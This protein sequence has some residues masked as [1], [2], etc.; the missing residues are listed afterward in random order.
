MISA[1]EPLGPIAT[2]DIL[3]NADNRR[4]FDR[5]FDA[6]NFLCAAS[7]VTHPNI[8][9]GRRGAGKT[10]YL[11]Y[12]KF[13]GGFSFATSI[14]SAQVFREVSME[15]AK[16]VR[17][18]SSGSETIVET[19]AKLWRTLLLTT[20]LKTFW[21]QLHNRSVLRNT[22]EMKT[23]EA[24]L[25]RSGLKQKRSVRRILSQMIAMFESLGDMNLDFIEEFLNEY[26]WEDAG[27]GE[28][29][30][31]ATA[32]MHAHG[33]RGALLIDS[34]EQFP[35]HEKPMADA[36]GGLLHFIGQLELEYLPVEVTMCFQAELHREFAGL[37]RNPEKDLQRVLSMH[38]EPMELLQI[39]GHRFSV[40][41]QANPRVFPRSVDLLP[42]RPGR[43]DVV[44][45]WG[46]FLPQVIENRFGDEESS[47]AYILRHTQLLPRHVISILNQV[48]RLALAAREVTLPFDGEDVLRGVRLGEENICL[49][50]LSGF[51]MKYPQAREV[52][53]AI[54]PNIANLSSYGDLQ[55]ANNHHGKGQMDTAEVVEMLV[56][57]G[58][59]GTLER[60]T[61][62][63]DICRYDYTFNGAM[64]YSETERFGLHPA[65]AGQFGATRDTSDGAGFKKPIYPKETFDQRAGVGLLKL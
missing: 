52:M 7:K 65:F 38:W 26:W 57:M 54:L 33:L 61:D 5:V 21:T 64:P 17:E 14:D 60:S 3:Q 56:R 53:E 36:L 13:D 39:C 31:A 43:D 10:A 23:V 32:L 37:S 47:I 62:Y 29:W 51:E 27:F 63:Y 15:I 50:V 34:L 44:A 6:E 9:L 55:R 25:V 18:R 48:V 41:V 45:F 1:Q 24:F 40:F 20:L 28:A 16:R 2:P 49:G 11:Y 59:L 46:Q 58:V 12:L 4:T 8:I 35:V 22:H 30:T 19:T 42:D